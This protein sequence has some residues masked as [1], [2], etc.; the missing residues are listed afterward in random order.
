M[1]KNNEICGQTDQ[2]WRLKFIKSSNRFTVSHPQSIK[3][4][5][6]QQSVSSPTVTTVFRALWKCLDQYRRLNS[7]LEQNQSRSLGV[8]LERWGSGGRYAAQLQTMQ[9]CI[10][11]QC[12]G[13]AACSVL[14]GKPGHKVASLKLQ[15][16]PRGAKGRLCACFL[17]AVQ[18]RSFCV[19]AP[20][21]SRAGAC[22]WKTTGRLLVCVSEAMCLLAQRS[23]ALHTLHVCIRCGSTSGMR[24]P[25]QAGS[26]DLYTVN[27]ECVFQAL[28][29]RMWTDSD[30]HI[31][32]LLPA[33]QCVLQCRA[34]SIS[35]GLS[36]HLLSFVC[37]FSS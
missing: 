23:A 36:A 34:V 11:R 6:C 22:V 37:L 7:C 5:P 3:G 35:K 9:R 10:S 33:P 32:S 13:A 2:N 17:K 28:S 18:P 26:W 29:A 1:C 14:R 30:P 31:L 21:T 27:Q 15:I 24:R 25:Q 12:F 19:K 8:D 16:S 20:F 4:F